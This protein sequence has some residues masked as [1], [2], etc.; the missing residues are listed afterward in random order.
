[1]T[2][3]TTLSFPLPLV[4]SGQKYAPGTLAREIVNMRLTPE[5]TIESVRGPTAL[6]PD[7]GAGYP[8]SARMYGVFHALLHDGMRDV[9]LIRAGTTLYEQQGWARTATA[10]VTGLSSDPN[11]RYPDQFVEVAGKIVWNNGIDAP[12]IYDGYVILPLG[13]DR[14]PGAPSATGPGDTGHQVFRNQGG[15]SHPGKIGSVGNFFTQQSGAL[16]AGSWYYYVQFEDVFGNRSPLSPASGSVSLRQEL[17]QTSFWLNYDNYP[18]ATLF[19]Q[20]LGPFA[21][22]VDDLTKQFL[23]QDIPAGPLGTVR[24]LL[25][26]T[27]DTQRNPAEAR[28]LAVLPDNV[29]AVY[30]DNTPDAGLGAVAVE[31]IPTPRFHAMCEHEG[32]LVVL[33]G[34]TLRKSDPGFP[35]SFQRTRYVPVK[36]GTAVFTFGGRLYAA[37]RS[38]LLAIEEGP[39]GSLRARDLNAGVGLVGPEAGDATDLGVYV[40][41]GE[42]G[43][44]SL[45]PD[46]SVA[47]ISTEEYPLFNRLNRPMLS[48]AVATWSPRDRALLCA[49]PE[50]GTYGNGLIMCWDGQGWRRWRLGLTLASMC[51]TKDWRRY[52]LGA[53]DAAGVANVFVL[54]GET[55]TFTAPTKTYTF[56]SAWLKADPLGA[57]RFNIDSIY[58]GI[59]E[60]SKAD[61]T[62][63]AWQNGSRDMAVATDTIK[64]CNP[65]T[66]DVLDALVLGT[67]KVRTP[68]LTWKRFDVRIRSCESFAFDLTCTEPTYMHLAAF[69]FDGVAVDESL[70]RV[71]RE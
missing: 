33:D 57:H 31:Y 52:V 63:T 61:I 66:T 44:W 71:S 1:M 35:G 19:D 21:V 9:V 53:G 14:A 3:K 43:W 30:P 69:V 15:Y 12:Q 26:R 46:E 50:A 51:V 58:V 38:A 59:V 64:G 29:T 41:L 10:L 6:I 20:N 70:A 34:S 37:T 17:T 67:G 25:Y 68:R 13:Y 23:V 4:E 2:Q 45:T 48:G 49:V 60:S 22:Q 11:A 56:R 24:R 62:W 28:L 39:G 36:G 8:Y 55:Q 5:G 18:G 7:Y 54:H 42:S 65:A 47:P 16:L 27:P 32:C 40:G